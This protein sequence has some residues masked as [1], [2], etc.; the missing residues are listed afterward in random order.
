M[1]VRK[2]SE[3]LVE[4]SLFCL[5]MSPGLLLVDNVLYIWV[6][7]GSTSVVAAEDT[8][9]GSSSLGWFVERVPPCALP[10]KCSFGLRFSYLLW[11][12]KKIVNES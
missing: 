8:V 10:V 7:V 11:K 1:D 5:A 6:V 9:S 12:Y 2:S 3:L 4:I